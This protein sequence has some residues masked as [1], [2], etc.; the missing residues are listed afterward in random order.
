MDLSREIAN[1]PLGRAG[2][3]AGVDVS[4]TASSGLGIIVAVTVAV[5]AM[6]ERVSNSRIGVT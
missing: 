4:G 2:R 1:V 3:S 6:L 5:G